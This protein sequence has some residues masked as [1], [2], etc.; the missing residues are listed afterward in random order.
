MICPLVDTE[1]TKYVGKQRGD[2]R[3]TH[4]LVMMVNG[5]IH[6]EFMIGQ[7]GAEQAKAFE[8]AWLF[9]QQFEATRKLK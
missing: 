3:K 4:Q 1:H 9:F 2:V 6:V 7:S 5:Y 8:R